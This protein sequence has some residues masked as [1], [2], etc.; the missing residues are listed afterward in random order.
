MNPVS[1]ILSRSITL[2][3]Y[4]QNAG[5]LLFLFFLL[6]GTQ[7]SLYHILTFHYALIKSVL[8]LDSFFFLTLGVWALYAFKVIVFI[9][10]C[11]KKESYDFI[12]G[13][14]EIDAVKKIWYLLQMMVLLLAPALLYGM[15]VITIA[16]KENLWTGASVVLLSMIVLLFLTTY[17]IYLIWEK[18]KGLQ[19]ISKSKI[20]LPVIIPVSLFRF[21]LRFIF[22]RQFLALLITKLLSFSIIYFFTRIE[23]Q[24][25]ENRMLWLIFITALIGHSFIIYRVFH[26][27]E[28]DLGLYRNMPVKATLLLFT[29]FLLYCILLLP[30]AWALLGVAI[31][32]HN[33]QDYGWM[34]LT[35]PSLLLLINSLL[36]TEDMKMEEFLKLLFGIW[37]VF[38]LFSLSKNH[39]LIPLICILFGTI[40]FLL[41]YRR[42]EKNMEVEGIE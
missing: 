20:I 41:S 10:G 34:L 6:F 36:Y 39:W 16:V 22:Q 14:N 21:C 28:Q 9:T 1:N 29:L 23:S 40:I 17:I 25:F 31:N 13:M 3:F 15:V 33:W 26:F 27:I 7:P 2:P 18:A 35:G 37:I 38:I 11:L 4:R 8:T 32:Q 19:E 30:E 24:L 42:Y 12:F 5:L